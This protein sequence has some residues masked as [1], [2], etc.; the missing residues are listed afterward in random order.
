VVVVPEAPEVA[1][2]LPVVVETGGAT[3]VVVV[4]R[5]ELGDGISNVMLLEVPV[6]PVCPAGG[7]MVTV[8]VTGISCGVSS[9]PSETVSLSPGGS[10]PISFW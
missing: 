4:G 1:L 3:V 9:G 6:T 7:V 10:V 2:P 8:S 5:G